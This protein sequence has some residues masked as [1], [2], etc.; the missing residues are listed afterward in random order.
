MR[1]LHT[2]TGSKSGFFGVVCGLVFGFLGGGGGG[3]DKLA[4]RHG[5]AAGINIRTLIQL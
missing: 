2:M 1:T 3:G 5:L 4:T